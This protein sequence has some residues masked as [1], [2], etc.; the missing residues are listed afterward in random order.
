MPRYCRSHQEKKIEV[1]YV[2]LGN[3]AHYL[4]PV[5]KLLP[6][7]PLI[8]F[9]HGMDFTAYARTLNYAELF[10]LSDVIFVPS[11]YARQKV[12]DLGCPEEK[13]IVLGIGVDAGKFDL[14]PR[15]RVEKIRL[16]TVGRL[17]EKKGLEYSIRAA[18]KV[19]E[20]HDN[21]EYTIL[22]EGPMRPTLEKLVRELRVG[23]KITLAG[24]KRQE[25]VV[26]YMQNSD[27]FVLASVTASSGD[28]E[29]VGTVLLEAQLTGM[30]V[31]AT[32]HN[33]FP[34]AVDDG[35]SGFLVPER[36]V[37]SLAERLRY[38]IDNPEVSERMGAEG[39][40]HVIEHFEKTKVRQRFLEVVSRL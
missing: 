5:K 22:G 26:A 3:N 12:I 31:V 10:S 28:T 37:D 4:L 6:Y 33:G 15:P 25:E 16:L 13:L 27:I 17:A 14:R 30:P 39:R 9:F 8:S 23:E 1:I 2:H 21:L 34:D 40:K 18:A 11:T 29:G 19:L 35:V 24:F 38:L 36:D 7:L 20:H 32:R